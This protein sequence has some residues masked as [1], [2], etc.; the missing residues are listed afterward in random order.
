MVLKKQMLTNADVKFVHNFACDLD[1]CDLA[2]LFTKTVVRLNAAGGEF[3]LGKT[4]HYKF[5]H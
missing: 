1:G 5:F 3:Y 4:I 2:F